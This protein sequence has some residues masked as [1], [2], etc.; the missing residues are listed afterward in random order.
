MHTIACINIKNFFFLLFQ[1]NGLIANNSVLKFINFIGQVVLNIWAWDTYFIF[2]F[3]R[4][5]LC[6][7]SKDWTVKLEWTSKGF[8]KI[9]YLLFILLPSHIRH[10]HWPK[11][12]NRVSNKVY[13]LFTQQGAYHCK[14][15]LFYISDVV[16]HMWASIESHT[17]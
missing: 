14:T 12:I 3:K 11:I 16:E 5:C 9:Y 6:N 7:N 17:S 2:M 15:A 4:K 10:D 1:I 8:Y 13:A